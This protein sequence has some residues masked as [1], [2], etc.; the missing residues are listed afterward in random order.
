MDIYEASKD[1]PIFDGGIAVHKDVF[2]IQYKDS[3]EYI[4]IHDMGM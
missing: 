3:A 4:K 2:V 1:L